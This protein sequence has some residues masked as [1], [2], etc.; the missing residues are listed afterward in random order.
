MTKRNTNTSNGFTLV[1]VMLALFLIAIGVLAAAPMFIYAMKGNAAGADFGTAGAIA[2]ER[3]EVL[4][5]TRYIDLDAG[6]DLTTDATVAG[7]D[8]FDN[9]D[10]DFTVRWQIADNV[11]P[12]DTKT[13]TVRVTAVRQVIGRQKGVTLTTLRGI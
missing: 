1:E 5:S 10:P 9:S 7:V 11:T 8:Y 2:V 6:G 4:R 12:A 13:I 3:M